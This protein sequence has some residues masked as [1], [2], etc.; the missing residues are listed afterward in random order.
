MM[1]QIPMSASAYY[2]YEDG[3]REQYVYPMRIISGYA[4]DYGQFFNETLTIANPDQQISFVN[5]DDSLIYDYPVDSIVLKEIIIFAY[6]DGIEDYY[7]SR[8]QFTL[9]IDLDM[10]EY[11]Y[12]VFS[13]DNIIPVNL[14]P[15]PNRVIDNDVRS[16]TVNEEITED[17]FH[18]TFDAVMTNNFDP[19]NAT[20][21]SIKMIFAY[22][23]QWKPTLSL[24]YYLIIVSAIALPSMVVLCFLIIRRRRR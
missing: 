21:V 19:N 12:G 6:V 2:T 7:L 16:I 18:N 11:G 17:T 3:T 5:I 9:S 13:F 15:D 20:Y 4:E 8:N 23:V 24:T 10:S 14:V 1:L 22:L